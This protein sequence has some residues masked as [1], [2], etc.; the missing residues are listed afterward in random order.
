MKIFPRPE[1]AS[2]PAVP[3]MAGFAVPRLPREKK[4]QRRGLYALLAF[5]CF[6]YSFFVILVP[7]PVMIPLLFPV[8]FLIFFIVWALPVGQRYPG[9]AAERLFWCYTVTLLLW[10]NYLAIACPACPG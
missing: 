7:R 6:I 8:L 10:P 5:L 4:W 1:S 9:K 3:V 2:V